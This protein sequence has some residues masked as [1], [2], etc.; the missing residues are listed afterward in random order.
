MAELPPVEPRRAGSMRREERSSPQPDFEG[1][2]FRRTAETLGQ[3]HSSDRG[4][5]T[6][7]ERTVSLPEYQHRIAAARKTYPPWKE[8][9]PKPLGQRLG[10][11][12]DTEV[13]GR[14]RGVAFS[15]SDPLR[16]YL[17][18]ANGGVWRSDDGGVKWA[19]TMEAFDLN[20][21][22]P[23]A[24]SLSCG[25]IA[26][27][28]QDHD[29]VYVGTGEASTGTFLGIGPLVS[30]VGGV[31]TTGQ[32]TVWQVEPSSP[33]LV[34]QGFFQLAVSPDDVDLVLG[35]TTNGL[36]WRTVDAGVATWHR[37]L[38]GCFTS[39]VAGRRRDGTVLFLAV[40]KGGGV[41]AADSNNV[42][43]PDAW[44]ELGQ[45]F[46]TEN[47][48]RI[49]LALV[50]DEVDTVFALAAKESG[51]LHGVYR[52]V[53]ADGTWRPLA[54]AP[55]DLFTGF[56]DWAQAIALDPDDPDLF[57]LG[58]STIEI[59]QLYLGSLYRCQLGSDG[60]TMSFT[61]IG[62]GVHADIQSLA[63]APGA[64][65]LWVA[66]DGGVFVAEDPTAAGRVFAS[67]NETLGTMTL[68]H[69]AHHPSGEEIYCGT[70][71]HGLVRYPGGH[72]QR[73]ET[74]FPGDCS[75]VVINWAD[76]SRVLASVYDGQLALHRQ[77]QP[78]DDTLS[79]P[80]ES[81]EAI[82]GNVPLAGTP[83]P[84]SLT[85]ALLHQAERV[86]AGSI[87]PWISESFGEAGSWNS[88]PTLTAEGDKLDSVITS[89]CFASYLILY[90]GTQFG[91]VYR[92][93]CDP[94]SESWSKTALASHFSP[95]YFRTPITDI[96]AD[97]ADPSGASIYV[98]LGGNLKIAGRSDYRRLWHYDG[99]TGTWEPRSGPAHDPDSQ[100]LPV[101]HN[102]VAVDPQHPQRLWV[103]ADIGVWVSEDS[104][105]HWQPCQ[106]AL[107]DASV[108][109][110]AFHPTLRLLRASTHGRGCFELAVP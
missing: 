46:P 85:P 30:S 43:D 6:A 68:N 69:L 81:G 29:R 39:V 21:L 50:R 9:G 80:L 54:G 105:A 53:L 83:P 45:G 1:D 10:V 34:G 55:Q 56:G 12:V 8:L 57:Y 75:H 79:L 38:E 49:T 70:Q 18:A 109:D 64:R 106:T 86:A 40:A 4:A 11:D 41:L 2:P 35:A 63:F 44:T 96:A 26:V 42:S 92:F 61:F 99:A 77:G 58:G 5:E 82:L 60:Q 23:G 66:C 87:R 36:Y 102:A 78:T 103:G 91:G 14:A 51:G 62:Y 97:P 28:P 20:P 73:W 74:V 98:T 25:A 48:G 93:D 108:I 33:S 16:I 19:F 88:I 65:R 67:R 37:V 89:L 24:D 3:R 17:A 107:P 104:G 15:R 94:Q 32:D 52:L 76:P 110:L 31:A 13:S 101:Q 95:V 84:P 71:D 27:A 100:L 72:Q 59:D 22:H 47:L 7:C 90:A